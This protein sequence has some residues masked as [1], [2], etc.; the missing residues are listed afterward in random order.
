MAWLQVTKDNHVAAFYP[1][2]IHRDRY[3]VNFNY[4]TSS[5]HRYD[6][7]RGIVSLYTHGDFPMDFV[8]AMAQHF[9]YIPIDNDPDAF[10]N[11]MMVMKVAP[12]NIPVA[13]AYGFDLYNVAIFDSKGVLVEKGNEEISMRFITDKLKELSQ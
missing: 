3:E 4:T 7:E 11:I 12:P 6:G 9:K 13:F 10:G 5:K 8:V 1:N 2:R